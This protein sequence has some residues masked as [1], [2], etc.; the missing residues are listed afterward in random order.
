MKEKSSKNEI[1]NEQGEKL[2]SLGLKLQSKLKLKSYLTLQE[3]HFEN[4]RFLVS[5]RRQKWVV[6]A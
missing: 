1:S 4:F 2:K 3:Q 5:R 6:V